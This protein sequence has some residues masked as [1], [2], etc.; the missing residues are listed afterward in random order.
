MIRHGRGEE[1][2]LGRAEDGALLE[3][4]GVNPRAFELFYRRHATEVLGF[5]TRR[6]ACRENAADL[7]A[8]TFAQAYLSRRRYRQQSGVPTTA[9]LYGI[10]RHQLAHYLRSATVRDRARR[11][12]GIEIEPVDPPAIQRV[13][14]LDE[15]ASQR[16]LIR[17]AAGRLSVSVE[18]AV[19]LRVIDELPYNEVA[20][21]LGCSPAAARQRVARGLAQL[22]TELEVLR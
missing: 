2:D 4:A 12:L 13:D 6:T 7:T 17:Q 8:E 18:H 19:R 16:E 3:Q 5:F 11:R 15:M 10:A 22:A 9:W 14:E 1:H 20:R 21:Q